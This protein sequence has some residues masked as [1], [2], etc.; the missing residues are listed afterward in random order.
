MEVKVKLFFHKHY[1]F[2]ISSSDFARRNDKR[3][4]MIFE[5][6]IGIPHISN[7]TRYCLS[8]GNLDT[9]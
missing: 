9:F 5:P 4:C 6:S 2:N 8:N 7:F 1:T 3:I